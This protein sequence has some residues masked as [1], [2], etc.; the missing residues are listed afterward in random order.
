MADIENIV[1]DMGGVLMD[2]NPLGIARSFCED[3]DDARLIADALFG[4]SAWAMLDAGAV[5]EE[6]VLWLAKRQLPE[7]L[8]EKCAE[9][10]DRWYEDRIYFPEANEAAVGLK[11]AGYRVYLLTNVGPAFAEIFCQIPCHEVFSGVI[12]SS[13][14]HIVKPDARIFALL[15]ERFGLAAEHCLFIDDMLVNVEGA[16]RAGMHALHYQGEAS[17]IF[18]WLE[19]NDR[20]HRL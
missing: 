12:A 8:H 6:T 4:Q 15:C 13:E 3:E 20:S 7:R 17:A 14:E 1:F 19:Q 18:S 2:W 11:D 10:A 9:V 5:D 16:R